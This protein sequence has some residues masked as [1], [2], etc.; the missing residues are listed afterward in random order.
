MNSISTTVIITVTAL[1]AKCMSTPYSFATDL[2]T[3]INIVS[4]QYSIG[5]AFYIKNAASITV[6][7]S[8]VYNCYLCDQ[9]GAFSLYSTTFTDSGSTYQDNAAL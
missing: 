9:G 8:K 6:L 1:D 3:K 7:N 4:P 5:G 2:D